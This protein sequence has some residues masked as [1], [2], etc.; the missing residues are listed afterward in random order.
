[1]FEANNHE[2]RHALHSFVV[3]VCK[4]GLGLLRKRSL[5]QECGGEECG[6]ELG[7]EFEEGQRKCRTKKAACCENASLLVTALDQMFLRLVTSMFVAFR[8]DEAVP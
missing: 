5:G 8:H 7:W 2:E 4:F 3:W 6:G 1:M